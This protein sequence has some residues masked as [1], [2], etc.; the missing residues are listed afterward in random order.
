MLNTQ[1]VVEAWSRHT[2]NWIARWE[3]EGVKPLHAEWRGLAHGIGETVVQD[4]RPGTFLGID[5]S[6]GML[7]REQDTTHLIPLT[8]LLEEAP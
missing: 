4:G 6:F 1:L 2:L 3:A 7:L 8:T 5:E